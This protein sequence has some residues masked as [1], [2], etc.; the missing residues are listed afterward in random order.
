MLL[1]CLNLW[2]VSVTILKREGG[3]KIFPISGVLV[4][5]FAMGNLTSKNC[6]QGGERRTANSTAPGS[7]KVRLSVSWC[8]EQVS[9]HT[10][11]TNLW[12]HLLEELKVQRGILV[13][14]VTISA[15]MVAGA[16]WMKELLLDSGVGFF[17]L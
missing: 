14:P 8:H 4:N 16:R 1:V 5:T 9:K 6:D 12:N 11:S 3:V 10:E 7:L 17:L 15:R 2:D 13:E